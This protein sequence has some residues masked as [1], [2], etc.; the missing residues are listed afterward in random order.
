MGLRNDSEDEEEAVVYQLVY[1]KPGS[2]GIELCPHR[3]QYQ[4]PG[5]RGKAAAHAPMVVQGPPGSPM[6]PGDILLSVNGK[7]C[8]AA[9]DSSP[10]GAVFMAAVGE[11]LGG[12]APPR[13]L[14]FFRF[15]GVD[16]AHIGKEAAPM[17]WLDP[18]P[19]GV[20]LSG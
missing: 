2:M 20:F 19:A 12:E 5:G 3:V 16:P 1:G 8:V 7:P 10:G 11:I 6:R 14:R 4:G 9:L 15:S 17:T 13:A 18:R